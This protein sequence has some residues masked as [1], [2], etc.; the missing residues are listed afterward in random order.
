[1]HAFV[2][3]AAPVHPAAQWTNAQRLVWPDRILRD[4]R[5]RRCI[6]CQ[7]QRIVHQAAGESVAE[8]VEL[9]ARSEDGGKLVDVDLRQDQRNVVRCLVL[10]HQSV[11]GQKIASFLMA[12]LQQIAVLM[13]VIGKQGVVAGGAQVAAQPAQHLIAKKTGKRLHVRDIKPDPC[14]CEANAIP[15]FCT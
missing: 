10:A 3:R 9:E 8:P 14:M 12:L 13:P 1:M 4:F 6:G 15:C 7:Q 2:M 11:L 5:R